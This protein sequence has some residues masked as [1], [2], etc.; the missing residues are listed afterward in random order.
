M[1]RTMTSLCC[2]GLLSLAAIAGA[3]SMDKKD[4]TKDVKVTGCVAAGTEADHF[5]LNH[6][7]MAGDMKKESATPMSYGLM[8]GALKPHVGHKVEVTGNWSHEMKSATSSD[9]PAP[10]GDMTKSMLKVKSVKM[11]SPTCE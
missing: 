7:T 8:G 10:A 1:N 9:K 3:Q 4:M 5:M 6:A 11:I 2:S